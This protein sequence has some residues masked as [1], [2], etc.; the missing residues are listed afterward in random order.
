MHAVRRHGGRIKDVIV[1][2]V[3]VPR[4]WLKAHGGHSVLWRCT[5]DVPPACFRRIDGPETR[6]LEGLRRS[7]GDPIICPIRPRSWP[8]RCTPG[9]ETNGRP[10]WR[11]PRPGYNSRWSGKR[12]SRRLKPL[13]WW[14]KGRIPEGISAPKVAMIS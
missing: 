11:R 10:P 9:Q 1:V 13:R 7:R 6:Q 5:R 3:E 2:K 4:D 14:R 8:W 12:A